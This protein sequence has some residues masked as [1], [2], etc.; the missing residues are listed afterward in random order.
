MSTIA[1]QVFGRSAYGQGW[2]NHSFYPALTGRA[3]ANKARGYLDEHG[4]K[5]RFENLQVPYDDL[6]S[7]HKSGGPGFKRILP[8]EFKMASSVTSVHD[9]MAELLAAAPPDPHDHA[10][11]PFHRVL[12]QHGFQHVKSED[13]VN[14]LDPKKSTYTEHTYAHPAHGKS[15]VRVAQEHSGGKPSWI[16]RHEQSNGIMAPSQG[17]T[18]PQLHRNLSRNYGE[19]T[20]QK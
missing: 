13:K 12:T 2:H 7:R 14:N 19:P 15:H 3:A 5:T 20:T 10:K 11:N 17:D 4:F 9:R 6:D 8:A 18:K 16:H 1:L